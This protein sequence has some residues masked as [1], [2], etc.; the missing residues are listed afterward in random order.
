M[1]VK[2]FMFWSGVGIVTLAGS[3]LVIRG[4]IKNEEKQFAERQN[5]EAIKAAKIPRREAGF[6]AIAKDHADATA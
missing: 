5:H 2:T 1:N 3:Y 6:H 4:F